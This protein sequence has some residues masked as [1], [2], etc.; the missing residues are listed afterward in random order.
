MRMMSLSFLVLLTSSA[1]FGGEAHDNF[2]AFKD[3]KY[4]PVPQGCIINAIPRAV[5][6]VTNK[7][8]HTEMGGGRFSHKFDVKVGAAQIPVVSVC[9]DNILGIVGSALDGGTIALGVPMKQGNCLTRGF[10]MSAG[11]Y[12]VGII[13]TAADASY[14]VQIGLQ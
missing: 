11:K 8:E 13:T 2:C 10:S 14:T 6:L 12:S 4:Q 5:T 3:G 1:A 9:G 7:F